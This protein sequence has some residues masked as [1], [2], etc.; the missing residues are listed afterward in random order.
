MHVA[1]FPT[2]TGI[3]QGN[4]L[5][6]LETEV[7]RIGGGNPTTQ[8]RKRYFIYPG[9]QTVDDLDQ[10]ALGVL[11]SKPFHFSRA[12]QTAATFQSASYS[13]RSQ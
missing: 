5:L 2:S 10:D 8:V 1:M 7:P 13:G 9:Y 4:L 3:A 6:V 11:P 12:L